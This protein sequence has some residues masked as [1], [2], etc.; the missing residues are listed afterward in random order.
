MNSTEFLS[1][2]LPPIKSGIF[3]PEQTY[4][5]LALKGNELR[6]LRADS[7]DFIIDKCNEFSAKGFDTYMA[8][9]SFDIYV[10]GRKAANAVGAQCLWADL[11][12]KKADCRYQT[13]EEALKTLVDF[14]KATGLKPSII[15]SSGKGLHVYWLLNR[16]VN[17][18]EWKQLAN[19]FLNL[20]TKHNM[21]V[22]RARARDIA[23]V[24]RLPGTVHQKTGTTVSILLATDRK[25]DPEAFGNISVPAPVQRPSVQAPASPQDFFGMG[26]EEPVYDGVEIARNCNQIMTMG[27]QSYPNW[28]AAMSVLRRCK[29]GLAVAKVL[30]SACPEKYNEADTEKRFYEAYPDRPARCDVFRVGNPDGCKGCKY[31]AV[32]NS[33]ASLRAV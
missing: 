3:G 19:N 30:S 6:S 16:V 13:R 7:T 26:P 32:L 22:D 5:I 12:I 24:L 21:D 17:A 33:P 15:V 14:G 28:F 8:M 4:Y 27:K 23:S 18:A 11:D 29:N 10:P 9:A 20:C 1:A 2:I 25:Y 31:A